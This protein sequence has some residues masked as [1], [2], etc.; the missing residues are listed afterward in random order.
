MHAY[1]H[2]SQIRTNHQ[3]VDYFTQLSEDHPD[4]STGLEFIEGLWAE[5]LALTAVIV[6]IAIVV[7]SIVW[8]VKGGDL[9]TVFTVMSFVLTGAAGGCSHSGRSD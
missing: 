4:V 5:K 9:Q 8:C 7:V 1:H 6:T 2:P 3:W